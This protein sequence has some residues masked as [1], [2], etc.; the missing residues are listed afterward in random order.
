MIDLLSH[1]RGKKRCQDPFRL[2]G[3]GRFRLRSRAWGGRIESP[4]A[5]TSTTPS[6]APTAGCPSS[7]RT[8]TTLA[9]ERILGEALA[10]VPGVRLL[11]YC[12]MPNHWHLVLWPR[13]DGELSDFGRWLTLTHT[14]RWHAHHHDVG[15]GHL[16]QGRFK[17]FPVAEDEHFLTRLPL[18]GAQRLAGRPGARARSMALVQPVAAATEAQ[19]RAVAARRLAGRRAVGVGEGGQPPAKRGG[20][21]GGAA[22]RPAGPALRGGG[23]VEAGGGVPGPGEHAPAAWPAA[24]KCP[25]Q[26]PRKGS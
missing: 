14:Q 20:V 1:R 10:H 15:T 23:V 3:R 21:G 5:G 18:R 8:A 22:E 16:Y 25:E 9:F 4:W 7:R 2:D 17:S 13:R 12:L 6:I 26:G 24:R 11:A 19:A